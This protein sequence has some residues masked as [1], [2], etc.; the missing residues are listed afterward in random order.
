MG[1]QMFYA[2]NAIQTTLAASLTSS[3]VFERVRMG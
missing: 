2:S 3:A 1:S